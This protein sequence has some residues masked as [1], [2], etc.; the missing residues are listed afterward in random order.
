LRLQ[1][2]NQTPCNIRYR[3]NK[4]RLLFTGFFDTRGN[5]EPNRR[6]TA[7]DQVNNPATSFCSPGKFYLFPLAFAFA[8]AL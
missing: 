4:N 2:P 7:I 1:R 6:I 3:R 8:P 5:I